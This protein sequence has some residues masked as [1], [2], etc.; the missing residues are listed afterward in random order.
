MTSTIDRNS[1]SPRTVSSSTPTM[2]ETKEQLRQRE[3]DEADAAWERSEKT[4]RKDEIKRRVKEQWRNP[5][6]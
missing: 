2:E 4:R 1:P 6:T 3:A 5:L